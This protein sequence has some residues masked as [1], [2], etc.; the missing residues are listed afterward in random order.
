MSKQTTNRERMIARILGYYYQQRV[1]LDTMT[2]QYERLNKLSFSLLLEEYQAR[3]LNNLYFPVRM[4]KWTS[5]LILVKKWK[6]R[7]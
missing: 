1:D 2:F 6:E 4:F 7:Q 5:L 3:K